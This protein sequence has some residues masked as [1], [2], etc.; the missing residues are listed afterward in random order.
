MKKLIYLISSLCIHSSCRFISQQNVRLICQCYR[1]GSS[2]LLS[3]GKLGRQLIFVFLHSHGSKQFE[4]IIF[5]SAFIFAFFI[6]LGF[7]LDFSLIVQKL[8]MVRPFHF[9]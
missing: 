2:L 1:Y 4:C 7:F 3:T 5:I 9:R 6:F 8:S